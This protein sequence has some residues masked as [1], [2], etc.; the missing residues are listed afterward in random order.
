VLLEATA[1]RHKD[2]HELAKSRPY[3]F[4]D[5]MKQNELLTAIIAEKRKVGPKRPLR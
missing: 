5:R 2:F 4:E 1:R 3:V